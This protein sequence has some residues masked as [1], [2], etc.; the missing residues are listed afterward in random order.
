VNIEPF[1]KPRLIGH[2]FDG[3]VV[4]LHV[5]ADFAVL[6]QMIVEIAKWK[7][8][9]DHPE[10]KRVPR[11]F[12]EG[13]SL[14]LTGLEE[15][16]AIPIVS[17][18]FAVTSLFPTTNSYFHDAKTDLI[19]CIHEAEENK[20][21]TKLPPGLLGFFAKFGRS[22]EAGESILF[23]DG[24]AAPAT[25]TQESRHRLVMASTIREYSEDVILHG[26]ITGMEARDEWFNLEQL[27]GTIIEVHH[28]AIHF[29][30]VLALFNQYAALQ[31]V[32][33]RVHATGRFDRDRKLKTIESVERIAVVDALDV[34][35]RIEE[36]KLLRPG[37]LDGTGRVSP[38][39]ELDQFALLFEAN[40]PE[41]LQLP[42]L[43]P[44]P[45]GHL[46]AEWRLSDWSPSMEIDPVTRRGEWHALN[47]ESNLEEEREL[48]F[49]NI[50]DWVWVADQ[51]RSKGGITE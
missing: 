25:L 6:E 10:R 27:D 24:N 29:D 1:L 49:T 18:C 51:V 48:D 39:A 50:E 7:Y 22:L 26:T 40:Y 44:M 11:G 38:K 42:Y 23:V 19:G 46:S 3:G 20:P 47:L 35:L 15:G 21:I 14:K 43:F 12:T 4:P 13:I 2:R 31:K 41:D 34:R 9:I 16:S 37:W 36:L 32:K 30:T 5:L 17:I 33:V 8:R 45:N 28:D